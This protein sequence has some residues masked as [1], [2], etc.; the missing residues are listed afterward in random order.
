MRGC[1]Y[2]TFP[3]LCPLQGQSAPPPFASHHATPA[4]DLVVCMQVLEHVADPL[5]VLQE[6]TAHL[7]PQTRLYVEVPHEALIRQHPPGTDMTP[8]KRHWHEHI[9]FFTEAALR[10]LA[11]RAGLRVLDTLHLPFNNGARQGEVLGLLLA[12]E[13]L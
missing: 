8:H 13:A 6:L 7:G 11:A 10:Q 4:Y 3:A 12:W 1:G 2:T 9:N 5:A